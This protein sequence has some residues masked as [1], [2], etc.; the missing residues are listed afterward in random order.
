MIADSE[1]HGAR[2]WLF[3]FSKQAMQIV[4]TVS[5]IIVVYWSFHKAP[6]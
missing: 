3:Y 5:D 1:S 6:G 4:A 2:P